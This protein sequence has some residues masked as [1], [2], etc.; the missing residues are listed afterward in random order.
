MKKLFWG[1]IICLILVLPSFCFAKKHFQ[2][3]MSYAAYNRS[4]LESK[5]SDKSLARLK[6]TG[7]KWV[8]VVPVG[9]Q[10]NKYSNKIK[11]PK[12]DSASDKSINHA[13]KKIHKLGMKVMLKPY[14]DAYDDTW[15]A[16]FEPGDFDKWFDSYANFILEF[17]SLAEENNVEQLSIGV[18]YNFAEK[19]T[20]KWENLIEEIRKI[21]SGKLTYAANWQAIEKFGG[22]YKNIKFWS[23]LNFIGIDAYYPLTDKDNPS[24]K[25]L[26]EAWKPKLVKINAWRKKNDFK[27]KKIIFTEIGYG[28]YNGSNITPWAYNYEGKVEDQ[29]EQADCYRAFFKQAYPKKWLAGVYWWWW[30]N[31]S[32]DDWI[33]GGENYIYGFT[34]K[35]KEAE[36]VLKKYY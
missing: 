12:W 17:T 30:D 26:R 31:S 4:V 28:S 1:I 16:E 5:A 29:R 15:R 18:E 11:R 13:I 36:K 2:K 27:S 6:K 34:P 8:A 14:V 35:G 7:T 3:G 10:K 33:D 22:G 20:E 25:E 23:L 9:Y 32:T 21:Y 19:Y 24:V